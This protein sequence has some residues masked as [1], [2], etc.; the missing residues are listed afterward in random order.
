V[1]AAADG[2][3]AVELFRARSGEFACVLLDLMMPRL[4]GEEVLQAIRQ[5]A[6]A[7]P[8]ILMSGYSDEETARRFVGENRLWFLQKPFKIKN[9]SN[10]FREFMPDATP[11]NAAT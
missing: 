6:P 3:E 2:I 9:I 5:I 4:S 7:M 11:P 8:V 10:I 1:I